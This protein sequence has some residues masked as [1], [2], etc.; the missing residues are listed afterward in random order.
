MAEVKAPAVAHYEI[1]DST[2]LADTPA[3]RPMAMTDAQRAAAWLMMRTYLEQRLSQLRNWRLSW[4]RYWAKLA[5]N[6][7]PERYHWLITP[8]TMSRGG[9]I[10]TAILDTTPIDA[11]NVCAA[12][13]VSGL[14]NPAR[15]WFRFAVKVKGFVLDQAAK[16]WLEEVQ[17]R[18]YAVLASSNFYDAM[19]QMFKDL[20]VFGTAPVLI[21]EHPENV[22]HCQNPCAGEYYLGVGGDFTNNVFARTFVQTVMQM[23]DM[24]GLDNCPNEVQLKW[25]QPAS[26]LETEYVIGHM[27][28]P[29]FEVNNP[30]GG[31]AF[32]RVAGGFAYRE[33]Y[34]LVGQ[35]TAKPLSVRGFHSKPHIAPRWKT[36]SNDAYGRSPGMDA[37][38]DIVQ[39]HV[40]TRRL[41][42][43]IEKMV[44]PPMIAHPS[45]RNEPAS[46]LPGKITYTA[47]IEKGGMKPMYQFDPRIDAMMKLIE[48]IQQ[49]VRVRFFNDRFLA[50]SSMEGVQPRN[51]FELD[52]RRMENMQ[53]LGPVVEKFENEGASEALR[54]VVDIMTRKNLLPP[55]PQ[56]L[57]PVEV[58]IEFDSMYSIAQRAAQTATMER[59]MQMVGKLEALYPGIKNKIKPGKYVDNYGEM[60]AF[61]ADVMN[62]ED[63]FNKITAAQQQQQQQK[64]AVDTAAAAAPIA[65]DTAKTL[66]EVD[67]GQGL[68][69]LEMMLG[70]QQAPQAGLQ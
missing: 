51:E 3:I 39:L 23:V 56:S 48:Q 65:A 44:R 12:G 46:T 16:E 21:Y 17:R 41:N 13:M 50:I 24:F 25:K 27:I 18:V 57:K 26:N 67:T 32:G 30:G 28:E 52:M 45:L 22:I 58:E 8:N 1:A 20:I 61:P 7:L 5:E 59:T 35:N 10:N 63:E 66:S 64:D 37:L 15:P 69:A 43:A 42:E 29:N 31:R 53:V 4:W 60:L 70:T 2:L 34:W 33:Y 11:V 40:M 19:A 14:T 55:R 62:D 38:G 47:E 68:S 9:P 36:T 49:R 6:I 54:R